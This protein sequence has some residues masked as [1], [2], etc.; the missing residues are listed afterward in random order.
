MA[1]PAPGCA[2]ARSVLILPSLIPNPMFKADFYSQDTHPPL[3]YI[4]GHP[5]YLATIIV[6]LHVL[7]ALLAAF[8]GNGVLANFVYAPFLHEI[9]REPWRLVT[10]AFAERVSV[11]LL[12]GAVFTYFLGRRFEMWFGPKFLGYLYLG[13]VLTGSG[14]AFLLYQVGWPSPVMLSGESVTVTFTLFAGVCLLEPN[15]P[16]FGIEKFPMK[17]AGLISLVLGVLGYVAERD[18]GSILILLAMLGVMYAVLRRTGMPARFGNIS[19]AFQQALPSR[20]KPVPPAAPSPVSAEPQ[21]HAPRKSP[22]KYYEP[23]IRPKPDLAPERLAV[24]EIDSLLDKIARH[25][26][27]SLSPDEKAA[28]QRASSKLKDRA[29]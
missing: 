25:G 14:V 22:S 20:T 19:E 21:A 28:L 7:V 6:A 16:F 10:W 18:W 1:G 15:A 17:Y 26:L 11:W 27:D 29:D 3:L 8:F 4:K 9:F 23:K 24:E 13:L 5:V 12:L 2:P